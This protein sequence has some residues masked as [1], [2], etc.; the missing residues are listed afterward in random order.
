MSKSFFSAICL[1]CAAMALFSCQNQSAQSENQRT[2]EKPKV[3]TVRPAPATSNATGTFT[4][5]SGIVYWAGQKALGDG[6]NGNIQVLN[7]TLELSEGRL[8]SGNVVL[9][10]NT[11]SVSDLKDPEE[12]SDLES[13]LKDADFFEVKK[14]PKAE[15]KFS[16]VYPSNNPD[17]NAVIAGSL[18]M[19]GKTKSVNIPVMLKINEDDL[20][21]ESATFPINR[22]DWGV[23]FRSGLLGT[24]KDKLINDVVTLSISLKAKKEK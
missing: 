21:A 15:F 2:E 13:H 23:N 22:T 18:T 20:T 16:E 6:H 4:L 24:A 9:D 11:V 3:D 10:M 8:L 19:K 17:F 1:F 12:K 7:G 14:F 5:T